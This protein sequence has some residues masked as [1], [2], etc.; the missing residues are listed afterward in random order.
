LT[1]DQLLLVGR[2]VFVVAL[3]LFLVVLALL[4]R[5]ELRA[6]G[7]QADERAPGDLLMVEP[8]DTG[9]ESGERIPLLARSAVGRDGNNDLVL[10]DSFVSADHARI[11]WNGKGWVVE[12][13]GSTN[14]TRVNGKQVKRLLTVK[15]GDTVEFGRVKVKLV[16][17]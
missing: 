7:A 5:R 2:V 12:D 13:L 1:V 3:Y 6:P 11:L 15:P 8:Y 10:N 16:A 17:I 4:L 9:Y 14:G